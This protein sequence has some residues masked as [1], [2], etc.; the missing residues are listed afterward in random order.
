MNCAVLDSVRRIVFVL[1]FASLASYA[2]A[3]FH[4]WDFREI[5]SNGDGSVQFIEMFTTSNSQQFT[6][7][8][9]ITTNANT[10]TFP[11]NTPAPTANRHLLLAT[12]GFSSI[13]GV[14]PDFVIP[15]NFFNPAADTIT[16]VFGPNIM[17]TNAPTDGTRS[18][19]FPGP[20]ITVNSPTNFAGTQGFIPP[21]GDFDGDGNFN[22]ADVNS[23]VAAI[24]GGQNDLAFD[25]TG[26]GLV[27]FPDLTAWRAAAGTANLP[28]MNPYKEG[29]ANLDGVVD[30]SDFGIWNASKFTATAAWCSGDFN[31]DGFVDGSD[32]GI[33]NA[34][35]FTSSDGS[36][37]VPEPTACVLA[38]VVGIAFLCPR[39]RSVIR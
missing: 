39:R 30:G 10:F 15:S 32:F 23:L 6:S 4:L 34:N 11:S 17:F 18:Y 16:L 37:V 20:T 35:K 1:V 27:S 31:A 29:D 25:L 22:C 3:A 28:S 9:R 14:T 36:S 19:T 8:Q 5:Y 24:A 33:W 7:G 38:W 26:D 21:R 2:H 13:A 12:D